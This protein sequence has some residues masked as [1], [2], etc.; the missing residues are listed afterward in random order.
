M[1]INEKIHAKKVEE[2]FVD[3]IVIRDVFATEAGEFSFFD[4]LADLL[5]TGAITTAEAD[6]LI[7][8]YRNDASDWF[9][10]TRAQAI[11][12]GAASM[13]GQVSEGI[14]DKII[15]LG[16]DDFAVSDVVEKWAKTLASY[17]AA[18]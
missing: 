11:L 16:S 5:A 3:E 13:S 6:T 17:S 7:D 12:T 8:D 9:R 4:A 10:E 14:A 15:T 18:E 2:A 1:D